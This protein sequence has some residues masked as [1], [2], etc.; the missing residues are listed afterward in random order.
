MK[1]KK[2][3]KIFYWLPRVLS[4]L[5]IVFISVFAL[6]A[7]NEPKWLL[8]LLIHLI[9][10]YILIIE[11]IIAWKYEKIGGIVFILSGVIFLITSR[12][13]ATVVSIPAIVIGVLFLLGKQK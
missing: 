6:D 5:F 11:T 9:P 4:I 3:K 10:T 1:A 2:V 13:Q 8:A 7:F 12:F